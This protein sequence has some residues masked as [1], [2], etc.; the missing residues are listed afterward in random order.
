MVH[1]N[2][3]TSTQHHYQV[4]TVQI[5]VGFGVPCQLWLLHG[6]AVPTL[7]ADISHCCARPEIVRKDIEKLVH[8]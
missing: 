3:E 8:I 1:Y 5:V 4:R 7:V 2:G 6:V